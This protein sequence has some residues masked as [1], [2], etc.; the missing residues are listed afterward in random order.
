MIIIQP[1][2]Q[3]RIRFPPSRGKTSPRHAFEAATATLGLRE[4]PLSQTPSATEIEDG[5]VRI[6]VPPE[7]LASD[8]RASR[9]CYEPISR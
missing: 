5:V 9:D 6:K 1:D 2:E 4:L 7:L 3:G 8:V